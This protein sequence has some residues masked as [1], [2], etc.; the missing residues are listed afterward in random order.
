MTER[1]VLLEAHGVAAGYSGHPVVQNCDLRLRQGEVTLLMG[2]NGAGKTT[3]VSALSGRIHTTAGQILFEGRR[4]D[5]MSAYRRSRLGIA[6]VPQGREIVPLMTVRENL[7]LASRSSTLSD[8]RATMAF[9]AFPILSARLE[10]QATTLSGGEQQMLAISRALLSDPKLILLDE[11]S[12]GLAPRVV[13]DV[14]SRIHDLVRSLGLTVLLVEQQVTRVW[15]EG[16]CDYGYVLANGT[17]ALE[18]PPQAIEHEALRGAY[19]GADVG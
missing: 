4:I 19:L 17:I 12:L 14:L 7:L 18:G 2:R 9:T 1:Q 6:H 8:E 15:K 11:P 5:K 13:E 10:Q 3:L 16:L